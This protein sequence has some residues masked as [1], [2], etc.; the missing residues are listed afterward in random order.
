MFNRDSVDSSPITL[1]MHLPI[2]APESGRHY[3]INVVLDKNYARLQEIKPVIRNISTFPYLKIGSRKLL[4]LFLDR[5]TDQGT[6]KPDKNKKQV[7]WFEH[8]SNAASQWN[9]IDPASGPGLYAVC[10]AEAKTNQYLGIERDRTFVS[11][12]EHL[13]LPAGYRFICG[14]SPQLLTSLRKEFNVSLLNYEILNSLSDSAILKWLLSLRHIAT[15]KAF[16]FGDFRSPSIYG[17]IKVSYTLLYNADNG[18]VFFDFEHLI[19]DTIIYDEARFVCS[20]NIKIIDKTRK[21][22]ISRYRTHLRLLVPDL[23]FKLCSRCGYEIIAT[24]EL[25]PTIDAGFTLPSRSISFIC[26]LK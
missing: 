2:V 7:Q 22:V 5:E 15:S 9:V 26:Q 11:F 13:G 20:H 16:L 3:G 12:A 6:R 25:F 23:F 4:D 24:A 18:S 8:N 10:L 19:Q 21:K 1:N 17:N 14:K